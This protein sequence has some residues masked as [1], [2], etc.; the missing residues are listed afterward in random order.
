MSAPS[1]FPTKGLADRWLTL[2]WTELPKAVWTDEPPPPLHREAALRYQHAINDRDTH[3]PALSANSPANT[4]T[5]DTYKRPHM[6][7]S[8]V[9]PSV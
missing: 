2:R 3:V 8:P 7:K 5:P 6:P 1:A 4:S 9:Q